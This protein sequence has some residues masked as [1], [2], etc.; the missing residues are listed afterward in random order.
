MGLGMLGARRLMDRFEVDSAPGRGTTV[1]LK[2]CLPASAPLWLPADAA[3]VVD[4]LAREE[5]PNALAEVHQQN[6]ELLRTLEELR[7]RQDELSRLNRELEDTNRGVLALYAELDEK[8]DH[9]RRADQMKSRFLSNMSHEFRTP[10]NSILAL[11]RLLQERVD[12]DLTPEQERQVGFIRK[13][14]D[15][16]SELVNDLLDLA[17]VEAGKI[18]VHPAEFEVRNLIGAL[19]GMLRPLLVSESVSLVFEE[20]QELPPLVGDEAKVSQILR[21][22][23]SNALKFTEAGEV[24]VSCRAAADG[25]HVVFSVA[26][27]GIGIAP[28]DQERIFQEFEQLES[29]IQRRVKGTGLGLPLSRKLAELLGGSLSVQSAVGQGSTF[30]LTIPIVYSEIGSAARPEAAAV[31]VDPLRVPVLVV[32]DSPEDIHTYER[33]LRGSPFQAVP[34]RTLRD[35]RSLMRSAGPKAVILDI[36]LVGED[37]WGFLAEAKRHDET[38]DVPVL[39]VTNVDD[40][41]KAVALGADAYSAKPVLREWLIETLGALTGRAAPKALIIDD[42]DASRYVLRTLL[43]AIPFRSVEARGGGEGLERAAQE[44]PEAIFLDLSMPDLTGFEVLERLRADPATRA[45]PVVVTSSKALSREESISLERLAAP[46]VS[47]R[48]WSEPHALTEIRSA[49]ARAGWTG[50]RPTP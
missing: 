35:A 20:P 45:T 38:K 27:T 3:R 17:K 14:A 47:K 43:A 36:L 26:D 24:R 10:L 5:I 39:V 2:R 25:R 44:R 16:L 13:A 15:D 12:G 23:I 1:R 33:L 21:N 31:E 37:A 42:E 32:D 7:A 9:L 6:H 48:L 8:A 29:S 30:S 28:E 18:V 22:F 34:A 11:A 46:M 49:L 19:R 50:P 40:Q 41:R 4:D